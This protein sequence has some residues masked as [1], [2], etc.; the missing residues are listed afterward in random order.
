MQVTKNIRDQ[1]RMMQF[2]HQWL[3]PRNWYIR[4]LYKNWLLILNSN[5]EPAIFSP[6][7]LLIFQWCCLL[8]AS[9]TMSSGSQQKTCLISC[10]CGRE[11][12]PIK[13][14]AWIWKS[15]NWNYKTLVSNT[16]LSWNYKFKLW[17]WKLCCVANVW[18]IYELTIFVETSRSATSFF[19]KIEILL[20]ERVFYLKVNF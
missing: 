10:F 11:Q 1:R 8:P 2:V 18:D 6:S 17:T 12:H 15:G 7:Q 3:L 5:F 16:G 19:L 4:I 20:I 13:L 9:I 14:K